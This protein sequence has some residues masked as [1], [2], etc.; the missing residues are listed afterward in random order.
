DALQ[1][2]VSVPFCREMPSAVCVVNLPLIVPVLDCLL[3][4]VEDQ[5]DGIALWWMCAQIF[6]DGNQQGCGA[7]TVVRA[8]KVD[9]A[10]RVVGFVVGYENDGAVALAGKFDDEVAYRL[11]AGGRIGSELVH[12]EVAVRG[13]GLE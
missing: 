2:P 10:Q 12:L 5:P 3:A 9:V 4:I 11:L 8:Y 6:A 13:L 1:C 7:G